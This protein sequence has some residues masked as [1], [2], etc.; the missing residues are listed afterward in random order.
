MAGHEVELNDTNFQSEVLESD[1]P[2]L[3]D[4]WAPRCPPCRALAPVIEQLAEEYTG[5]AKVG[6]LNVD[7]AGSTAGNYAIS[8]IPT[9]LVFKGGQV[10][11]AFVGMTPTDR[12]KEALDAAI[13]G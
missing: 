11:A 9:L 8:S 7:E 10:V 1:L 6:K 3:V 4:F 12:L 2:V 13:A 5:K